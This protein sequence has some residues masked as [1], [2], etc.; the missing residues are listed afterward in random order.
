MIRK[1]VTRRRVSVEIGEKGAIP[2][3]KVSVILLT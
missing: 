1:V 3:P 2:R